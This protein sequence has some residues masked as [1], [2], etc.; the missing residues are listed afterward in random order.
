[1]GGP[2]DDERAEAVAGRRVCHRIKF[3][4]GRHGLAAMT[5]PPIGAP[6]T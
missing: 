4:V 3:C 2:Y 6:V 1:L 5:R